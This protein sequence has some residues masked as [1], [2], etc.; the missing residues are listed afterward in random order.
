MSDD[1]GVIA[2]LALNG[3][4]LE[5]IAKAVEA[6][7]A[8]QAG[9]SAKQSTPAPAGGGP[10]FPPYGRSKGQPVFGASVQDLEFYASGCRR[11]LGDPSKSRFHE[12]ERALLGAIEAELQRAHGIASE[13]QTEAEDRRPEPPHSDDMPF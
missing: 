1:I 4:A 3:E 7:A 13:P 5:R 6:I 11:S 8:K 10:V 2:A 12:K 9:S